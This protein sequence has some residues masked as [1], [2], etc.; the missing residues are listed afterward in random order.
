MERIFFCNE[1]LLDPKKIIILGYL[2]KAKYNLFGKTSETS[3]GLCVPVF[4]WISAS[5]KLMRMCMMITVHNGEAL[6]TAMDQKRT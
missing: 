3:E 5:L 1:L 2:P 6:V 4:V